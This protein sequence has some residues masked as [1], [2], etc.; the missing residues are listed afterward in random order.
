[1][2]RC[3][4]KSSFSSG[5]GLAWSLMRPLCRDHTKLCKD[6]VHQI[7][8][9]LLLTRTATNCRLLHECNFSFLPRGAML[10]RYM[11]WPCFCFV[12]LSFT[13]RYCIAKWLKHMTTQTTPHNSIWSPKSW[14]NSN[15]VTPTEVQ[16][17][18]G[19]GYIWRR[20]AN[21]SETMQDMDLVTTKR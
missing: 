2:V 3:L 10:A 21:I 16:N 20:L 11:L 14:W 7:K 6:T 17:T 18:G 12:C 9:I 15:G 19:V 4:V 8:N 5:V 1:M 13:S